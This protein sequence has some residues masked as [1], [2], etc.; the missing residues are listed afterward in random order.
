ML[1]GGKGRE[2]QPAGGGVQCPTG[3]HS[4][5][6]SLPKGLGQTRGEGWSWSLG[7]A[8]P[9]ARVSPDV[10]G[11]QVQLGGLVSEEHG[12]TFCM[13]QIQGGGG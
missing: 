9:A 10:G 11:L 12:V 8:A 1:H 2:V 7:T 4:G 13:K 3:E 6:S 5:L